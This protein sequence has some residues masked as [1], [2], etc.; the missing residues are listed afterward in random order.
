MPNQSRS[1]PG[2]GS[3]TPSYPGTF[4][5]AFREALAK[6]K[7][8]VRRWLGPVV[9]CLDEQGREQVVGLE[10]LFRRLRRERREQWPM[11]MADFLGA[12]SSAEPGTLLPSD[13][14]SAAERLLVRLGPPFRREAGNAQIWSQAVGET[15]L[16]INLVVDY[17]NRMCYVTEQLVRDSGRPAQ[18]WLDKAVE[19]L[20]ARTPADCLQLL[21]PESG[22]RMC[23]VGDAYDS[24]RVL[25]LDRLL[26]ESRANGCFIALPSRDQLLILP[27]TRES[28]ASVHLMKLLADKNYHTA[29]YAISDNVFWVRNGT[30]LSFSI[31][32]RGREAT[33]SPPAEFAEVLEKLMPSDGSGGAEG[34][35]EG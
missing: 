31:Q 18:E 7:W 26:P 34:D 2:I 5:L 1:N 15:G 13:L 6:A 24:S 3:P 9:E 4:L 16:G 32:I 21:D 8:Q 25:L 11:L 35:P 20:H 28:L 22:I 10:N 12:V 17:P 23:T 33:L 19:N 27:V 29:P 14:A 30:W